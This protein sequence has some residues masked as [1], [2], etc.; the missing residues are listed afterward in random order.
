MLRPYSLGFPVIHCRRAQSLRPFVYSMHKTACLLTF[1][2]HIKTT[3]VFLKASIPLPAF[4]QLFG[5]PTSRNMGRVLMLSLLVIFTGKCL[6][7]KQSYNE[8]FLTFP[9][10]SLPG[11]LFTELITS[12]KKR[13][14]TKLRYSAIRHDIL[15][16]ALSLI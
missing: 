9:N 3:P 2:F 10:L 16:Y 11:Y 6:H 4:T 14:L 5:T 1:A 8:I 13:L 15:L 7:A 12:V